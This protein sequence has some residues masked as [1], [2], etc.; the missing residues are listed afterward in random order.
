MVF[1]GLKSLRFIRRQQAVNKFLK[2]M[3]CKSSGTPERGR[4]REQAPLLPFL[5]GAR[6]SEVPFLDFFYSD[7]S[8]CI[9]A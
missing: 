7:I 9:S 5:K 8:Y 6:G 1:N 2:S 4:G 3:V